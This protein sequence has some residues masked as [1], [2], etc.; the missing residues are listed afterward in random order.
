MEAELEKLV[1]RMAW[2]NPGWGYDRI[3]GAMANLGHQLS[4]QTV[5]TSACKAK[6]SFANRYPKQSSLQTVHIG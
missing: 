1:L 5:T 4:D 2:D 3:V 6:D